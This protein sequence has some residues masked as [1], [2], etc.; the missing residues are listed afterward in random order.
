[1]INH[2]KTAISICAVAGTLALAVAVPVSAQVV[3]IEPYAVAPPAYRY[4]SPYDGF[5]YAPAYGL[6]RSWEYPAGYDSTG[7]SYSYRELGW[8][9]GPPS[10]APANPCWPSQRTINLC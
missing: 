7:S 9:P 8:Q 5:A 2:L 3:V 1:M 6:R 4:A 10:G